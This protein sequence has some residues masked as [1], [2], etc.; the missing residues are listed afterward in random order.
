MRASGGRPPDRSVPAGQQQQA[1]RSLGGSIEN[2][3]RLLFEVADALISVWGSDRVGVRIAPSGTFNGMADSDPR[4]LFRYVAERLNDLDLAYLHVIDPRIKGGDLI[5]EGMGPVAAQE[6]GQIFKGPII[7]AG[8]FSPTRRRPPSRTVSPASSRSVVNSSPTRTCRRAS[9][10]ACRSIAMTGAHS[11]AS[12]PTG[13]RTIRHTRRSK[14]IRPRSPEQTG[15]I[16]ARASSA[17]RT[18]SHVEAFTNRMN[19]GKDPCITKRS[20]NARRL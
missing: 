16:L 17:A 5:A 12:M 8:G 19:G 3:A 9:G 10:S 2:R 7:A 15:Q 1:D 20:H 13:T 6:L 14:P 11:M 4:T 18:F